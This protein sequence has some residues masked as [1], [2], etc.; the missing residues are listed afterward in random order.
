MCENTNG[1]QVLEEDASEEVLVFSEEE[2]SDDPK[3]QGCCKGKNID[4]RVALSEG[5]GFDDS[6]SSNCRS[7]MTVSSASQLDIFSN[8]EESGPSQMSSTCASQ[9][10]FIPE[11]EK[12]SEGILWREKYKEEHALK[13]IEVNRRKNSERNL[14]HARRC[15]R[16][17]R[18]QVREM[19]KRCIKQHKDFKKIAALSQKH[20]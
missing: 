9:I 18:L 4:G 5:I 3:K 2:K 10:E 8:G 1:K 12:P 14:K 19:K 6:M 7:N 17:L 11:E 20:N 16:D 15:C 13:E